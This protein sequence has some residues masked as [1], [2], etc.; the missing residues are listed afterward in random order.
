VPEA[1]PPSPCSS[2]VTSSSP[3]V[4]LD[5]P[6]ARQESFPKA[7]GSSINTAFVAMAQQLDLCDIR[8]VATSLGVHPAEGGELAAYPSSVI[9]AANTVAPL[10]MAS[11]FAAI[12]NNGV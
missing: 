10:T 4:A 1:R 8:D 12:G 2:S 9:G 11:A 3:A 7:T 5:D 6:K